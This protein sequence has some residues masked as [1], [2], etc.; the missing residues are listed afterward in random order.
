MTT[1]EC[2]GKD[3]NKGVSRGGEGRLYGEASRE[4]EKNGAGEG[5]VMVSRERTVP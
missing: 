2:L 3:Y 1:E 5:I 4:A